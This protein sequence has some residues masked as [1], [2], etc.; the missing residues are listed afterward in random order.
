LS[1]INPNTVSDNFGVAQTPF[2]RETNFGFISF[3]F[4]KANFSEKFFLTTLGIKLLSWD[5]IEHE[6]GVRCVGAPIRS[7][8]GQVFAAISV[9]CPSQR[10]ALS[11]V[12]KIAKTVMNTA[13]EISSRLGY[14]M[15]PG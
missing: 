3:Q 8:E 5:N 10:L 12:P 14:R 9:T 4:P 13:H 11:R 6:Q 7:Y 15:T 1:R 2:H